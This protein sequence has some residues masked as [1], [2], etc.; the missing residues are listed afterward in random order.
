MP[1]ES[2]ERMPRTTGRGNER[3]RKKKKLQIRLAYSCPLWARIR[4][5]R[6][7]LNSTEFKLN[8]KRKYKFK[9]RHVHS[10]WR[11]ETK[12]N[13]IFVFESEY[14]RKKTKHCVWPKTELILNGFST[15]FL[16]S[17]QL[18]GIC[19]EHARS[20]HSTKTILLNKRKNAN[21]SRDYFGFL[22]V[23]V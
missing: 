4:T 5:Q 12:F 9:A 1:T 2:C 16:F 8:H 19:I 3:R 11:I 21:S 7:I 18:D 17:N 22:R 14:E 15:L 13:S 20:S 23:C 6:A 10:E